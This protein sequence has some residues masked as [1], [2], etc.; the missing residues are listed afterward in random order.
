MQAEVLGDVLAN[1]AAERRKKKFG[2]GHTL[3]GGAIFRRLV[4][5]NPMMAC[6]RRET[7]RRNAVMR[8]PSLSL[9]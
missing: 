2:R 6:L 4:E 3:V 9:A 1:A 7:C 5:Q 8:F